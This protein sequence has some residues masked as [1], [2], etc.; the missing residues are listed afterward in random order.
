M[1]IWDVVGNVL[2]KKQSADNEDKPDKDKKPPL[3][4][5]TFTANFGDTITTLMGGGRFTNLIGSDAKV[6]F[7][8]EEAVKDALPGKMAWVE[9]KGLGG[10]V[11]SAFMGLGG[12]TGLVYGNKT[13]FH[14]SGKAFTSR[15]GGTPSAEFKDTTTKNAYAVGKRTSVYLAL[16]TGIAAIVALS[17]TVRVKYNNF[18]MNKEKTELETEDDEVPKNLIC[19]FFVI[20]E[21]RWL[22][23]LRNFDIRISLLALL[24]DVKTS[25]KDK[26][27]Q[28]IKVA[29]LQEAAVKAKGIVTTI[30]QYNLDI[31]AAAVAAAAAVKVADGEYDLTVASETKKLFDEAMW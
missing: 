28:A 12:D 1:S 20:C 7:D 4:A 10:Q 19:N 31:A 25:A 9:G 18:P 13:A 11:I 14:Y 21:D 3:I 5:T 15:R 2:E 26:L 27:D 16:F 30:K 17:V 29:K 8:W 22:L 23:F 24:E 6:V